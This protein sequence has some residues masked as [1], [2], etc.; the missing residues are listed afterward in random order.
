MA[1]SK[2]PFGRY[3]VIDRELGRKD[4]VKTKELREIIEEELSIVVSERMINEDINTMKDDPLLGYFAPIEYNKNKK[5]YYY[6]DKSY[7]IKAFGLKDG[8]IN[9]LMFYAKTINQYKEYEVF[10]DFTNAIEKVLDAVTIRKGLTNKEYARTIVQTE[11]TPKLTGSELIP[12]IVQAL[13]MNQVIEFEYQKFEDTVSKLV[14][15]QLHLL[16]EDRHRWY[17]LG[18]INGHD[19]PTTVYALDRILAAK[20]LEEK[21]EPAEFNFDQYFAHSF[22]ITVT[23]DEPVDVILSFTPFQGNY[24]KTLKIHHTQVTLVDN[25]AEYRISV[26]VIP[27]W[28]FYE[29]ILGYGHCVKVVSPEIIIEEVKKKAALI[30]KLYQ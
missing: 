13:D 8:D 11:R 9:A 7:T 20:I 4:W 22:G 2:H 27:S 28:E 1:I 16:K 15:L 19:D 23:N 3:Q 21:F 30:T 14:K 24:L 18:R 6:T 5:A 12:L 17:V 10:K 29:K 25:E 26:R